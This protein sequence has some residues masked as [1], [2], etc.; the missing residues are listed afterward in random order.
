MKTKYELVGAVELAQELKAGLSADSEL[1]AVVELNKGI[2]PS[3]MITVF[4]LDAEEYNNLQ[5]HP[6]NIWYLIKG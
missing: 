6:A 3:G 2:T 1:E 5:E 4:V